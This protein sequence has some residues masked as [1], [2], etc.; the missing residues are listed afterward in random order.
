M[1]TKSFTT[2]LLVNQ[3]PEEVFKAVLNV[4]GWWSG[5]YSEEFKGGT[6]KLNDEFSFRAGGDVHYSKQKLVE[7]I[8]N[9]KIVW[10]VTESKLSF[11]E[12]TDEWT[13]TRVIF[14]ISKKGNKTQLTFTHEGLTPEIECYNACAPAWTQ[15]VENKLLPLI[16]KGVVEYTAIR[17]KEK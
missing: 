15:Y 17:N 12:K 9:K 10:L 7:V 16:T 5:Y 14:D 8:P 11:L 3:T 2:T 13:G 1:N 4:R 6:E